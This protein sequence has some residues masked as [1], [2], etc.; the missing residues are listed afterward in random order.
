MTV[1]ANMNF[2]VH[3]KTAVMKPSG[4]EIAAK[5]LAIIPRSVSVS[6][7]SMEITESAHLLGP[8]YEATSLHDKSHLSELIWDLTGF[9]T[10]DLL[11]Y[12]FEARIQSF[13]KSTKIS[14]I[15]WISD[16]FPQSWNPTIAD[17][18]SVSSAPTSLLE[19]SLKVGE[20]TSSHSVASSEICRNDGLPEILN[21]QVTVE[22]RADT[23]L[24]PP[25]SS[26]PLLLQALKSS[27]PN[28]LL[29]D[30]P[31][32]QGN[33]TCS[34]PLYSCLLARVV[35]FSLINNFAGQGSLSIEQ[36]LK[37]L[38][39]Q[40]VP[41]VLR[42]IET[43]VSP[44][45]DAL[46]ENLFKSAIDSRDAKLVRMLLRRGVDPNSVVFSTYPHRYTPLERSAKLRDIALVRTL[47]EA[48]ADPNQSFE[49]EF[50][51]IGPLEHV[52]GSYG[53][54]PASRSRTYSPPHQQRE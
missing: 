16:W 15:L 21:T 7:K 11:F 43:V 35:I 41:R 22:N 33:L 13:S 29:P 50:E 28:G 34:D 42:Y 3:S 9:W 1:A 23:A 31:N 48:G 19:K 51:P 49:N 18:L 24:S 12:T 54:Y 53:H 5:T 40:D 44:A 4:H 27:L 17:A 2:H 26:N 10:I 39:R 36:T 37:F 47:V 30:P 52:V 38:Q 46:A 8:A 6:E 45:A 25:T 14:M 32:C 20:H